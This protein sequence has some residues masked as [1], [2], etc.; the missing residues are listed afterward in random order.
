[1]DE[2]VVLLSKLHEAKSHVD[3]EVKMDEL[4]LTKADSSRQP[5]CTKEKEE[6]ITAAFKHFK[7]I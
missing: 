7:M 5:N 6:A 1:M 3:V 4:D 2:T